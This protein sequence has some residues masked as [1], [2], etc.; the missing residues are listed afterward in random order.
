MSDPAPK[1]RYGR[2]GVDVGLFGRW[3][4]L[5]WGI[6][7]LAPLTIATLQDFA[8]GGVSSAFYVQTAL[9]FIAILAAY[10]VVYWF[11]GERLFARANP[12]INTAILVGP[13]VVVA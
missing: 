9:Y 11:L 8:D 3:S 4:R 6:L 12:W 10:T 5:F 7:I 1:S 13:A 2:L